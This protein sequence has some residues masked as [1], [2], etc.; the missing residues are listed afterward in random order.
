MERKSSPLI[1]V[2]YDPETRRVWGR[3]GRFVALEEF[4]KY[5][6]AKQEDLVPPTATPSI[7]DPA[8]VPEEP[9]P[10]LKCIS[11]QEHV[12]YQNRCYP[13]GRTC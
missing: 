1:V 12:C 2:Y 10:E 4:V 6:P 8:G 11:G 7:P 3:G 13:T 9:G 5:P